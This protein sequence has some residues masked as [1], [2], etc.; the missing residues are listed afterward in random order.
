MNMTRSHEVTQF[1]A[2]TGTARFSITQVLALV[3]VWLLAIGAPI[4]QQ[5]LPPEAQTLLWHEYGTIG[6]GIA[7]ALVI[8]SR[9]Q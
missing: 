8:F 1:P 2:P 5:A 9:K 7:I 6:I 3:L 4:I